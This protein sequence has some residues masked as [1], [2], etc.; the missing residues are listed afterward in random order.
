[1]RGNIVVAILMLYLRIEA[2]CPQLENSILSMELESC[3]SLYY[4]T[5]NVGNLKCD[6]DRFDKEYLKIQI[7]NCS[8]STAP[9]PSRECNSSYDSDKATEWTT[10]K[11][12][13]G[14]WIKFYFD[15]VYS[16]SRISLYQ[17]SGCWEQIENITVKTD[18]VQV[19]FKLTKNNMTDY[20]DTN[21]YNDILKLPPNV[22]SNYVEIQVNSVYSKCEGRLAKENVGLREISFLGFAPSICH[23]NESTIE[24]FMN[25][26]LINCTGRTGTLTHLKNGDVKLYLCDQPVEM[27]TTADHLSTTESYN[28]PTISTKCPQLENSILSMELESC[29][30]LY[31]QTDNVGNLKCDGDRF[32]KEYLKIQI[33][34]CSQSTAPKPSRECNSSYDSDKATEWTTDEEGPGAWIKFYFDA[35]YSISRISLYQ[36]SGCW[37][38]IENITVKTDNVQVRFKLTKNNMTD[39]LDTNVYNDILKLPPN[40]LSNYVEIQVNSVYSKCEGRLAKENVGLREISFLGFAPSICHIN[41]S[42]IENF[43]NDILINCTGRTGTLTNLKNGD[44]K[45]YLCDQPEEMKTTADHLSTTES[46]SV[47][48][49][50]GSE[51]TGRENGQL[52]NTSNSS[53]FTTPNSETSISSTTVESQMST[54]SEPPNTGSN[55]SKCICSC[56]EQIPETEAEIKERM[57]NT[58]KELTVKKNATSRYIATKISAPDERVSSQTMG[59]LAIIMLSVIAGLI[60][61]P[62]ILYLLKKMFDTL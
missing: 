45:L 26:I 16:I 13:P 15:A 12:G 40:V 41:E 28:V 56:T 2:K 7:K 33:K 8:Q 5:D 23:I 21:V 42:T 30:S 19:R 47:P 3:K 24:N 48:T 53:T 43:M 54:S 61:I 18:N 17:R 29:K 37:E 44:V 49:I 38:Q 20:L 1:M 50:S 58:R 36:R 60:I 22:L 6:G 9:K 55:G 4:Q 57:E 51:P 35:V 59:A 10:N 27:E 52:S 46:Y 34:N 62:D 11:E 31:Y 39:Y 14:A 25:D 32:D